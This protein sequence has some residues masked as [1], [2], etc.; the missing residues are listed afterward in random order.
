MRSRSGGVVLIALLL[1]VYHFLPTGLPLAKAKGKAVHSGRVIAGY[2][3]PL[4][5]G[6]TPYRIDQG[7]DYNGP[8][9]LY[10]VGSGTIIKTHSNGWPG[11]AFILLH[12]D[13]GRYKGRY[14]YYAESI[15]PDVSPGDN[16]RAGQRVGHA[17]GC[18]SCG[19]ELGW[20]ADDPL[21]HTLAYVRGQAGAG[22]AAGDA[23]GYPTACGMQ[24]SRFIQSLG[25]TPGLMLSRPVQGSS[26]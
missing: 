21:D 25:G 1:V 12:L 10:A 23:G 14:V 7:V 4:G 26:C 9:D 15:S 6:L 19:I 22:L 3:N 17:T 24:F 13:S 8:G 20:A 18:S 2:V 5:P 16:V 11:G